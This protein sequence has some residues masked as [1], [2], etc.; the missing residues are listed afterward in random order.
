MPPKLFYKLWVAL[1]HLL[2]KLLARLVYT[3]EIKAGNLEK[4]RYNLQQTSHVR[5]GTS[6]SGRAPRNATLSP[7]HLAH[8]ENE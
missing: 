2:C 3:G 6:R 1:L 4:S 8:P 7:H 5:R